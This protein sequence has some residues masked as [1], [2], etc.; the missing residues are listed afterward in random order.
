MSEANVSLFDP[1][2]M[3]ST[4][5]LLYLFVIEVHGIIGLPYGFL[6]LLA[7]LGIVITSPT[8]GT[9]RKSSGQNTITSNYNSTT[10]LFDMAISLQKEF[11]SYLL[12]EDIGW[13]HSQSFGMNQLRREIE[14]HVPV[15]EHIET[16][17]K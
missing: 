9:I 4:R 3:K 17:G 2:N 1:K 6:T 8:D 13:Y 10:D 11:T 12:K 16:V 14:N 7:T 15:G 5:F